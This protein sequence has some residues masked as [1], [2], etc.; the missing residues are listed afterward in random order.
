[1]IKRKIFVQRIFLNK[2]VNFDLKIQ[3]KQTGYKIIKAKIGPIKVKLIL[4]KMIIV[5]IKDY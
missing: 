1:M 5:K 3:Y 4:R 2:R